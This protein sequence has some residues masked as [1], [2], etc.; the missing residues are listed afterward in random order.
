MAVKGRGVTELNKH[1]PELIACAKAKETQLRKARRTQYTGN[2]E[3]TSAN[4]G[5][6]TAVTDQQERHERQQKTT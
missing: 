2:D 6:P 3:T 1:E 4:G 5:T